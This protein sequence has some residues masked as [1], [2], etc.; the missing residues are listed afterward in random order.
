[1][2]KSAIPA[3]EA[4]VMLNREEDGIWVAEC[5]SFPGCVSQGKTKT[6]ALKNL[7]EAISLCRKVQGDRRRRTSQRL[8]LNP[9][10]LRKASPAQLQA[11]GQYMAVP[12]NSWVNW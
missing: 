7:K 11:L 1:M 2:K 6:E 3:A 9:R 12:H 5:Q 8:L 10:A 4:K